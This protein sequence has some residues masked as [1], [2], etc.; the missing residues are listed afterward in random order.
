V[1]LSD[2]PCYK[3][4]QMKKAIM[5]SNDYKKTVGFKDPAYIQCYPLTINVVWQLTDRED[6][7]VGTD[8]ADLDLEDE[9]PAYLMVHYGWFD[10]LQNKKLWKYEILGLEPCNAPCPG[11]GKAKL[12]VMECK[13]VCCTDYPCG[14]TTAPPRTARSRTG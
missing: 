6:H 8:Q 3:I 10:G 7:L 12:N 2:D 14:K 1:N 5:E 4:K 9:Y 11:K 13:V